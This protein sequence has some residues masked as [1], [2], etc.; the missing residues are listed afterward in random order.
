MALFERGGLEQ[1]TGLL[2]P[3]W[4]QDGS[5]LFN[6]VDVGDEIGEIYT[7]TAGKILYIQSIV[8]FGY[9]GP[10]NY[11]NF[12]DINAADKRLGFMFQAS[13]ETYRFFFDPPIAF[14]ERIKIF[15]QD[16]VMISLSGWEEDAPN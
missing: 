13:R 6:L 1:D 11:V 12:S 9:N 15:R 3:R 14:T 8:V 4:L 16:E 10:T 7:V 5:V 2:R